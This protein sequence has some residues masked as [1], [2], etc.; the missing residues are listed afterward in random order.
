LSATPGRPRAGSERLDRERIL[1]AALEIIDHQ[2]IERLSMRR[3]GNALGVDPMAIYH[4]VPNKQAIISG[5]VQRVFEEIETSLDIPGDATWQDGV[6]TW[7]LTY[8]TVARRHYHLVIH[9]IKNTDAA[10]NQV[11]RV[12]DALYCVLERSGLPPRDVVRA[13]DMIVD[14]IHGVILGELTDSTVSL[15]W[16]QTFLDRIEQAPPGDIP[17]LRRIF[18]AL[19]PDDLGLDFAFGLDVIILGLERRIHPG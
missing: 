19:E 9:L 16:R 10:G 3:L 7:A 17:A 11:M 12:N 8:R 13:A 1:D 2:G 15:D 14:Y 4:H 6:R 18:G 5:L